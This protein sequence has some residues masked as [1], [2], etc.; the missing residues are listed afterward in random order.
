MLKR[1]AP[2]LLLALS[3]LWASAYSAAGPRYLVNYPQDYRQ[4]VHVRSALIGPQNP[5]YARYGGLHHIYANQLAMEGYRTGR[6]PD[7]SVIVFDL[8]ETKENAGVTSEGPRRFIDVMTKD[9]RQYD[10]TGGW[11]FEEFKGDSRTDRALTAETR[12]ACY[13]CH[14]TVKGHDFVFSAFRP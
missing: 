13:T 1:T 8:L 9:S 6:F 3:L 14:T 11:G 5:I 12:T 10:Q 7:G 2:I 4:W